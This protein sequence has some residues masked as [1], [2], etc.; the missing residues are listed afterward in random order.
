MKEKNVTKMTDLE[1]EQEMKS[2][3]DWDSRYFALE[4]ELEDRE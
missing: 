1:I 2:R 3:R 4:R